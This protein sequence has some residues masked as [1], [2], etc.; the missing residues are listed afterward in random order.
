[1]CLLVVIAHLTVGME[2]SAAPR[3]NADPL[4]PDELALLDKAFGLSPSPSPRPSRRNPGSDSSPKRSPSPRT[5][6]R[7]PG[8]GSPE[9]THRK[10]LLRQLYASLGVVGRDEIVALQ[11]V[12]REAGQGNVLGA[13]VEVKFLLEDGP[14]TEGRFVRYMYS[15]LPTDENEFEKVLSA[16]QQWAFQRRPRARRTRVFGADINQ[17]RLI[18][19]GLT[20][21]RLVGWLPDSNRRSTGWTV[22][23]LGSGSGR[24]KERSAPG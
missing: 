2:R 7:L 5:S 4:T 12:R 6:R 22:V 13:G 8:A 9:A 11:R 15:E 23:R 24:G 1:M 18:P 3:W 20:C 19:L 16:M 21:S 10:A 14:L 17:V